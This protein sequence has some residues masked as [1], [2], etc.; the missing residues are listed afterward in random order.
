MSKEGSEASK[1]GFED[2]GVCCIDTQRREV[3]AA[4]ELV[5]GTVERHC[6]LAK[7]L[8][9]FTGSHGI[10]QPSTQLS[11]APKESSMGKCM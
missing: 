6:G 4:E 10:P 2:E 9:S 3:L 8:T 5:V 7:L 11:D 1:V